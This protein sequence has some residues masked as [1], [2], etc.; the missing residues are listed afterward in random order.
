MENRSHALAA[1]IFV[2]LMGLSTALAVWYFGGQRETNTY[3]LES[4]GSV[5]G[6]NV[7]GQVRF[8]GIRA[9]K[10]ESIVQ[11]PADPRLI[12]V[13]IGIDPQFRLTRASTAKLGYQGVTGIAFVEIE[14]DG[15]S[16]DVLAPNED[17]PPRL[18]LKPSLMETLADQAGDI[19]GQISALTSRLNRVLDEKNAA[20]L[21]RTLDNVATA[22]EGLKELPQVVAAVRAALS[23]DNLKRL[24]ST[25]AHA[26]KASAEFAPLAAEARELV[27]SMT[28]VSQK[29]DRIAGGRGEKTADTLPQF[30]ALVR[31]LTAN[32]SQLGRILDAIEERPQSLLFGRNAPRPGPGETGFVAPSATEK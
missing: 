16:G 21:S 29:L 10:V 6:L 24:N 5:V 20:S 19:V 22:S 3:V 25:L 4:R 7:Q 9:G 1:G 14:D 30:N 31:Q 2:V 15:T 23:E 32:S 8:R 27:K 17:N 28:A 13:R 18:P 26:E 12:L 11:D